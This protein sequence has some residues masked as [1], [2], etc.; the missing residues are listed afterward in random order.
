MVEVTQA[1]QAIP[2]SAPN[3]GFVPQIEHKS[4]KKHRDG[5]V[6]SA[7]AD[8]GIKVESGGIRWNLTRPTVLT[9]E[10]YIIK[11]TFRHE[12]RW[13][14]PHAPQAFIIL[15]GGRGVLANG[16][17]PRYEA[18]LESPVLRARGCLEFYEPAVL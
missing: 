6:E 15:K 13:N 9:C 12:T 10:F 14:Q 5:R 2:N 16:S 1:H 17:N 7:A 11:R 4:N 3:E 8:G 18:V